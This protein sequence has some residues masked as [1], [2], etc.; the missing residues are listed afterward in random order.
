[1][2][3][4]VV[5]TLVDEKQPAGYYTMRWNGKDEQGRPVASDVY[6]YRLTAGEFVQVKKMILVR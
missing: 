2:L 6:L 5:K 1:M 4:Q 3:G